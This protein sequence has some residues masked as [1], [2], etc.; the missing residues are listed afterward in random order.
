M[1]FLEKYFY[2][3]KYTVVKLSPPNIVSETGF[4]GRKKEYI[5]IFRPRLK[6]I[7]RWK[8]SWRVPF[9]GDKP[10]SYLTPMRVDLRRLG[11]THMP[12]KYKN[13]SGT[14][15]NLKTL[16]NQQLVLNIISYW[17]KP[18]IY[19]L[20]AQPV[21]WLLYKSRT[22]AVLIYCNNHQK[23]VHGILKWKSE[24]KEL[25]SSRFL[26]TKK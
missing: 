22:W 11:Q 23:R 20:H 5:L 25:T 8:L 10:L 17:S 3:G 1:K 12:V 19:N 7:F 15:F 26:E 13:R 2:G 16:T 4:T 14:R 9:Y 24:I 18:W 21:V 6:R